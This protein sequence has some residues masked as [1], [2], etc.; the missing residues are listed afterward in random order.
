[1]FITAND[2]FACAIEETKNLKSNEVFSQKICL[3][4]INET[5]FLVVIGYY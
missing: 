3:K 4:V 1:M 2:L 5:E